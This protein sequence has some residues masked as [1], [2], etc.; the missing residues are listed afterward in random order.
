MVTF[1]T[2]RELLALEMAS[3]SIPGLEVILPGDPEVEVVEVAVVEYTNGT[4]HRTGSVRWDR[5]SSS[6]KTP[7][8]SSGIHRTMTETG[9]TCSSSST[10]WTVEDRT[11]TSRSSNNNSLLLHLLSLP[12]LE[13]LR[14]H[15][16][17]L[18]LLLLQLH[19]PHPQGQTLQPQC[20]PSTLEGLHTTVASY[21]PLQQAAAE[22]EEAQ[23]HPEEEGV[24]LVQRQNLRQ[25]LILSSNSISI[26]VPVKCTTITFLPIKEDLLLLIPTLRLTRDTWTTVLEEIPVVEAEEEQGT[27]AHPTGELFHSNSLLLSILEPEEEEVGVVQQVED[28]NNSQILKMPLHRHRCH[29]PY[30]RG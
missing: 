18:L 14:P 11:G 1:P 7:Q 26:S 2:S 5:C 29:R 21:R 19:L 25:H 13:Q 9:I 23:P 3:S 17:P 16:P 15:R 28:H 20:I 10:T 6:S 4:R 12:P 24:H 8:H 27:E 22:E 30:T